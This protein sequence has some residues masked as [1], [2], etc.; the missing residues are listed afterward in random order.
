MIK[1]K[2]AS[3]KHNSFRTAYRSVVPQMSSSREV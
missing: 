1:N 3:R 2:T